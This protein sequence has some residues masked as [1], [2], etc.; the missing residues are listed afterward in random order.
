[1]SFVAFDGS[2]S[3]DGIM[4]EHS[5]IPNWFA[6]R[7]FYN[8]IEPLRETLDTAAI[9]YFYPHHLVEKCSDGGI[10]YVREPVIK[11]LMFVKSSPECLD[12]IRKK[13]VGSV[14]PY[15]DRHTHRPLVIPEEQM[16]PFIRLC[17]IKDSG[18]EYLGEDG[19]QYHKGDRV[20]VTDGIFKGYEGCIRCIRHDRR[21][22][23]TIE[24][25]AAF[26][27]KFIPPAFLEK[28]ETDNKKQQ[29]IL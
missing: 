26:A 23:V 9:R 28:V 11:S 5:S 15:Y 10:N 22:I 1:M 14:A 19:P 6:L 7:I 8:R 12:M 21:L 24:G 2:D 3:S 13:H 4:L 18:L 20:R 27:T 25:V 29:I 16:E 17:D